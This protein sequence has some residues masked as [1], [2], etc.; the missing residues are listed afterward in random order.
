M[1]AIQRPA[2]AARA[3]RR[4]ARRP[5]C[6]RPRKSC[7]TC[8]S[9]PRPASWTTTGDCGPCATTSRGST[10]SCVSVSSACRSLRT[11]V[12]WH[13]HRQTDR[14][15]ERRDE[16]A[17]PFRKTREGLVVSDKMDKTVVV[18]VEDRVKHP[19]Y[20]KV[21]RRTSKLK[22]HDEPNEVRRRRPR[23]DHGDPSAV[24]HQ[25][26]ARR[27]GP[28]EGQV[29]RTDRAGRRD[30]GDSSARNRGAAGHQTQDQ[31]LGR[32]PTAQSPVHRRECHVGF[33]GCGSE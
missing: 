31:C 23:A 9:R 18:A 16:R 1:A 27:R 22:A 24:G 4:R 6:A 8:A 20:G 2:R 12:K 32:R 21:M 3:A 15:D 25:A 17:R 13:E 33:A 7:S 14:D 26:L 11:K 5:G 30:R 19:L 28:R 10:R 29:E